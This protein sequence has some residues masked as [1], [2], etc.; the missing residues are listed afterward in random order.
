[1]SSVVLGRMTTCGTSRYGLA[2]EA[3][4]T[5]SI[6]LWRTFSFPR[7]AMRSAFRSPGVPSTREAGTASLVGGPSNRPM[8]AGFAE[9]SFLIN[10]APP[11][12]LVLNG[13]AQDTHPLDFHLEDIAGLHENGWLARRSDA[14][15]RAGDDHITS[16]ETHRDT[17]HCDQR[18][19]AEDELVG[20]RILHHSAVQTAPDAQSAG[21]RRHGIGRH[22]PGA[23]CP[24]GIEILAHRPLRRAQLKIANRRIVEQGVAHHVIEGL[25][26]GDAAPRLA[27]HHG[28]LGFI[29][30]RNRFAGPPDRL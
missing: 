8:R 29:V 7:R 30:E 28:Q 1:M 18:G 19:D 27:D 20:T 22:Q 10:A 15:R 24:C 23:E 5:R 17:D 21:P 12:S 26:L 6:A 4:R 2:S 16:L 13:V 25:L 3:Y 14:T 11:L 9:N